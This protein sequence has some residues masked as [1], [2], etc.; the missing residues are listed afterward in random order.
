MDQVRP[1]QPADI[2]AC[3]RALA[4]VHAH[5]GYPA[6]W[7]A[8][9]GGWLTPDRRTGAWVAVL[10]GRAVGHVALS[11]PGE[12]DLAAALRGAGPTA[13]V[14]RLFV[15]PAARGRGLG[16]RLVERAVREARERG[17]HPVLDVLPG[18]R[19]A[20]ALYERLGWR[21]IGTGEQEWG[22]GRKVTVHC[23]AAPAAGPLPGPLPGPLAGPLPG[24]A[25]PPNAMAPGRGHD[26]GPTA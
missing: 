22:P 25:G 13:V 8:D 6:D 10:D 23:Y 2:D 12:G 9:P 7:P 19:A 21:R 20:I 5:D 15:D 3:V 24:L 17:A 26:Q 1:R 11:E 18:D 4:H 14:G 16:A